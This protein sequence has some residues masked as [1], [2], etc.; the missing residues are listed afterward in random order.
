MDKIHK[1]NYKKT[2]THKLFGIDNYTEKITLRKWYKE[3]L[4]RGNYTET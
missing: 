3:K 2:I 4:Y 1:K